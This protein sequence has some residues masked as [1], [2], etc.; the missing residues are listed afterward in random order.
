MVYQECPNTL[1]LEQLLLGRLQEDEAQVFEQ[2]LD[3]CP[4]CAA[5]AHTLRPSDTLLDAMREYQPPA[6]DDS[7]V[8]RRM[9]ERLGPRDSQEVAALKSDAPEIA[10]KEHEAAD[11]ESQHDLFRRLASILRP[12][13]AEDGKK[14]LPPA[15][16][17]DPAQYDF[18][19]PA[20]S[21]DELGRLGNYR[22]LSVLGSGGMGIVFL[23]ED[24]DLKRRVALKAMHPALA[25]SA[26]ARERFMREAQAV[27]AINHDHVVAIH[28]VG[29]DRGIPYLAMA[30]L[31]GQSLDDRIVPGRPLPLAD[32]LRIG[33]ETAAGLAAAHERGLVHR[34]VKPA[35]VWLEEP[36]GRVKLLDFGLARPVDSDTHFTRLGAVIGTPAF[37]S[38][39]QAKGQTLDA[40]SDLFSLGSML[41]LMSTGE[42][43][44]LGGDHAAVL[45]AIDHDQPVPP[46]ELRPA[47][48]A[49]FSDLVMQLL[50]KD[51]DQRPPS[52]AAV[53]DRLRELE[54]PAKP[55]PAEAPPVPARPLSHWW[56]GGIAAVLLLLLGGG[57]FYAAA[58][59]VAEWGDGKLIIETDDKDVK[60]VV[61]QE[62]GQP[63]VEIVERGTQRTY[64]LRPGD[65]EIDVTVQEGKTKSQ[66]FTRKLTLTQ[67][68]RRVVD[69]RLELAKAA[70]PAVAPPPAVAAV[71]PPAI[72]SREPPPLAQ[73]LQGRK[74]VTVA[75]D[76]RGDFKTIPEALQASTDGQVVKL[77]DQGPYQL[78][79]EVTF[80]R[81]GGLVSEVGTRVVLS[82]WVPG[83]DAP[84]D[85]RRYRALQL[86]CPAGMRLA[87]LHFEPRELPQDAW[88][89]W[90]LGIYGAGEIVIEGCRVQSNP[91]LSLS[92]PKRDDSQPVLNS[93][94]FSVAPGELPRVWMRENLLG[95]SVEFDKLRRY[96]QIALERNIVLGAGGGGIGV[97][98]RVNQL[99]LRH[100]VFLAHTGVWL[101]FDPNGESEGNH[102][103]FA[104]NVFQVQQSPIWFYPSTGEGA[105]ASP[106]RRVTIENNFFRSQRGK[107]IDSFPARDDRAFAAEHWR[108]G[109]N[110]YAREP[111][112]T[113]VASLEL[114]KRDRVVEQPFLTLDPAKRDYLRI[115]A[116]GPLAASGAG[117]DLPGYVGVVPPG[118]APVA[119]DWLARLREAAAADELPALGAV[120]TYLG[121][122]G[123]IECL[124]FSSD[125]RLI[126]SGSPDQTACLWDALSQDASELR[127]FRHD[128]GGVWAAAL[129][130]DGRFAVTGEG[131]T[132]KN[133]GW[134]AGKDFA[135]R[136]WNLQTG[137][138]VRRMEGLANPVRSLRFFPDGKSLLSGSQDHTVR[139]WDV[140]SGKQ[141][142]RYEGF[143]GPVQGVDVP[144][145]G[146][147][148]VAGGGTEA[149]VWD[150]ATGNQVALFRGPTTDRHQ[151]RFSA[152]A[153]LVASAAG[154]NSVR[155][156]K[157]RTGEEVAVLEHPLRVLP[158]AF[159]PQLPT[160]LL[161][162]C[163]DGAIYV[164]DIP[165]KRI[166]YRFPGHTPG[167][168]ILGLAVSPDGRFAVSGGTD[169]SVRLWRLPEKYPEVVTKELRSFPGH[170]GWAT[171]AAITPDGKRIVSCGADKSVRVWDLETGE[172]LHRFDSHKEIVWRV[173]ISPDGRY[174]ATGGGSEFGDQPGT[175]KRGTDNE[176]RLWDLAE[177]KEV[178]RFRGHT[179]MVY[180]LQFSPDNKRLLSGGA[181][182]DPTVRL[183]D[184]ETGEQLQ[185]IDGG[186]GWVASVAFHRDG[187]LIAWGGV[188]RNLC[189]YDLEAKKVVREIP[190]AHD[191]EVISVAFST[192]GDKLVSAGKDNVIHVWEVATGQRL[193]KIAGHAEDVWSACFISEDRRI[194]SASVDG[195]ARVW[196]AETSA[197]QKRFVTCG[198]WGAVLAPDKR[199]VL[200]F[201]VDGVL[202][203]WPLEP[204]AR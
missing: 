14:R 73:W 54:Q 76:G 41:Y 161:A 28:Q 12:P 95:G 63:L 146:S 53:I 123:Q 51:R 40:R 136:L 20:E 108:V 174:A 87:G 115:A 157:A 185:S 163:D 18:L 169:Q 179:D 166:W 13:Q 16:A 143:S 195:S 29:K 139:R 69:V 192:R 187:K 175:W 168:A 56:L 167:L 2:H 88:Q 92:I 111:G 145:D 133:G 86:N 85:A 79:V 155:V 138:L 170:E 198:L 7:A 159:H 137:E 83:S 122:A 121:H 98:P 109:H 75:Q 103:L 134:V 202:R 177:G 124:A 65:Y 35:N 130:P 32:M 176:I 46:R 97:P 153:A 190:V 48:P 68:D 144:F 132:W 82:D 49:A 61:K 91:H 191:D 141:R 156:W 57:G 74:F 101:A 182:Y 67:G 27:A 4:Q 94:F 126:L 201:G 9:V 149:R 17:N 171:S 80:K 135:L 200:T 52:A 33:R 34:D 160:V 184:V 181:Q 58:V 196:D 22:V 188:K 183:W 154:N 112:G 78:P 114:T 203:L 77:L 60:V 204:A 150:A 1:V 113:E 31:R 147:L 72:P 162:A 26:S 104:N 158:V 120:R 189:L 84:E 59:I 178:R 38:P 99:V 105:M 165:S 106:P 39:E 100:N 19:A 129:S 45:A 15:T 90:T 197:E 142:Q 186:V 36:G 81:G 128:T 193:K 3:R 55:A 116:E 21:A 127:T 42:P 125:S 25:A 152:D 140:A 110:V 11:G 23:A 194:L 5:K 172:Q 47:L 199:Q 10:P 64:S 43:P 44:F 6:A 24:L 117:G 66:F 96:E 119:G 131:E 118:P 89:P 71:N 93:A 50:A 173:A 107:G 164:W 70:P 180:T 8:A 102:Y 148:V 30:L 62:G 151:V 37:M